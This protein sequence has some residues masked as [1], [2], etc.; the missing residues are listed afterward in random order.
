MEA[1]R[2]EGGVGGVAQDRL[3]HAGLGQGLHAA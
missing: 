1:G 3:V 2:R